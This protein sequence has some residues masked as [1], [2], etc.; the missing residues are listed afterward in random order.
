MNKIKFIF[1][2]FVI[3]FNTIHLIA[4]EGEIV[5]HTIESEV[6]QTERRVKVFLPERYFGDT[7]Q[8]LIVT[9]ILDAQSDDFWNMANGIIG[10]LV[11]QYQV[12][13]MIAVGIVSKDRGEEFDPN[14]NSLKQHLREEVFPL[15]KK[16]YR[17]NNFRIIIGHSWGGA[18]V[19]NTLFSEDKDLF[20]VYIGVSPSLGANDG[21]IFN[22]AD[23]I[24]KQRQLIGKY[25]YC[26]SGD[27]GY[28]E[29][30]S[31]SEILKMDS[32]I[33]K[34]PNET[35]SWNFEVFEKKDHW[36]CVIPSINNG[37]IEASRNYF[38]DQK[39]I[40]DFEINNQ[41]ELRTQIQEFNKTQKQ[42]FEFSFVPNFKYFKFVADDFRAQGKYEAAKELYLL[43]IEGGNKDVVCHFNLAQT[44]G[45]LKDIE[46]AKSF[47]LQTLE[48]LEKQKATISDRFYDALKKEISVQLKRLE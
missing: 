44:Y 4:Q 30:E 48:L 1:S 14:S 21:I 38:A 28:R 8:T 15:I 7:T 18:F 34:Y 16:E 25:F 6:F 36:S 32:I 47:Y 26:S 29:N 41:K 5:E 31:Y 37:L 24:L 2:L 3:V 33:Q 10:Y 27:I 39:I 43:S 46:L 9:Y 19:G 11:R 40:E 45:S 22:K 23:S 20:N 12:I 13:P 42:N 17:V 35:F